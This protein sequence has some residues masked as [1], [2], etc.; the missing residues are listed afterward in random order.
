[1][2]KEHS[3]EG[4]LGRRQRQTLWLRDLSR[5]TFVTAYYMSHMNKEEDTQNIL[6]NYTEHTKM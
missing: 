4:Q 2:S 5:L 1:V 6:T 3:K